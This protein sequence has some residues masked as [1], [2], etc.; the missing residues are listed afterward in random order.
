MCLQCQM[1]KV[2]KA[3]SKK[4]I[5]HISEEGKKKK[6]LGLDVLEIY[7]YSKSGLDL[8]KTIEN[9]FLTVNSLDIFSSMTRLSKSSP[10]IS[11]QGNSNIRENSSKTG[12]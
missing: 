1:D 3:K 2:S 12:I 7:S 11:T 10:I 4:Q 6:N 9:C 8:D 5:K